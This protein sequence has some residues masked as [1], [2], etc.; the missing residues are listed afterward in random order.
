METALGSEVWTL[1]EAQRVPLAPAHLVEGWGES[2][3]LSPNP[4]DVSLGC[5]GAIALLRQRGLGVTIAVIT[6]GRT[7]HRNSRLYPA[8]ALIEQRRQQVLEAAATLGVDESEVQFLQLEDGQINK[9][10]PRQKAILIKRLRSL[11]KRVKT[12]LTPWRLNP[13]C[14]HRATFGYA[15]AAVGELPVRILEYPVRLWQNGVS[16]DYPPRANFSIFRLD[17]STVLPRKVLAFSAYHSQ[18][19]DR[20]SDDSKE[21][22]L[23][24]QVLADSQ[25]PWELF[26]SRK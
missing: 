4:A 5:G 9:L 24:P 26:F 14:D 3:V 22:R 21:S 18:P 12:V 13:N 11:V 7:S 25:P 16:A 10:S 6:D 19:D 23:P 20:I 17:I 8:S 15:L 1:R 2:L